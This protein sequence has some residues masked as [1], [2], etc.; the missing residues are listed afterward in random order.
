VF[1]GCR[2]FGCGVVSVELDAL[3][4]RRVVGW[5]GSSGGSHHHGRASGLLAQIASCLWMN[6]RKSSMVLRMLSVE[7]LWGTVP[8]DRSC[9]RAT[10]TSVVSVAGGGPCWFAV[11]LGVSVVCSGAGWVRLSCGE[12]CMSCRFAGGCLLG[13]SCCPGGGVSGVSGFRFS[14]LVVVLVCGGGVLLVV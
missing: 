14:A 9:L 3:M 7:G 6:R 2:A 13:V 11:L 10:S 8:G 4:V 5:L 12:S 1:G